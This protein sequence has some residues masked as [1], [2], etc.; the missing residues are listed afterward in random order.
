MNYLKSFDKSAQLFTFQLSSI[1]SCIKDNDS[2]NSNNYFNVDD[3]NFIEDNEHNWTSI[4]DIDEYNNI[5]NI[6]HVHI[7][8]GRYYRY[9]YR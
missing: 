2:T 8:D 1:N 3:I 6:S 4:N 5:A 7:R 9:R